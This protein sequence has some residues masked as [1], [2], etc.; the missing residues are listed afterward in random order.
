MKFKIGDRV[1]N[2]R[3]GPVLIGSVCGVSHPANCVFVTPRW[4][5]I[6]PDW[7]NYLVYTL[8]L[9]V[10]AV[11]CTLEEHLE[12]G[13]E[14]ENYKYAV[15]MTYTYFPESDLISIEEAVNA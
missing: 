4:D 2:R 1:T 9:E 13:G 14:Y 5:Q 6:Y 8:K 15:P 10:P 11:V 12:C 7:R 3:L